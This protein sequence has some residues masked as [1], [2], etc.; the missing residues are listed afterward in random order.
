MSQTVGDFL[1]D[2]LAAWGVDRIFGYPGDGINGITS[3]LRRAGDR[4]DFVQVRHE[5]TAGFL[6][7]A[8]VKYGGAPLGVCLATSGP[9]AIRRSARAR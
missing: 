5:E 8:Y 6:A 9:G 4:F 7:G 1:L 2:R 3:A